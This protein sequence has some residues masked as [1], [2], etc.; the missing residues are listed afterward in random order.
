MGGSHA[1]DAI[2]AGW[3]LKMG[4]MADAHGEKLLTGA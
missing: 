4:D 1:A 3:A 2:D